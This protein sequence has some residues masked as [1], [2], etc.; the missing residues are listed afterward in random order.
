[1]DLTC[2]I[3]FISP[4]DECCLWA[5]T[6]WRS[7]KIHQ[8][9]IKAKYHRERAIIGGWDTNRINMVFSFCNCFLSNQRRITLPSCDRINK[10]NLLSTITFIFGKIAKINIMAYFLNTLATTLYFTH[11]N[12]GDCIV[13]ISII[14]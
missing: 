3:Y 5:F 1:M 4:D 13:N 12:N 7:W 6:F 2:F 14:I 8:S 9:M 11:N 10:E